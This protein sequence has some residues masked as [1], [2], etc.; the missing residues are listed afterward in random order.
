MLAAAAWCVLA[1]GILMVLAYYV[2]AAAYLDAA[3]L[4]GFNAAGH[5]E[6]IADTATVLAHLCNPLPYAIAGLMTIALA[7][8]LRGPR[9]AAA[10]TILLAG[11]NVTS[12]VLKPL[13]AY[14][15]ELYH[16]EFELYNIRDAA[17]PSGHATAAMALSLAV[18]IIVPRAYRPITA[19]LGAAF[20]IAVS[21]SV[22][23]LEWH[24]PSDV[25]GG[26]LIA[27]GYGLVTFAALLYSAERWPERGTM[28]HAAKEAIRAPSPAAIARAAL[29]AGVVGALI[30]VSKAEQIASF[31]D[32]HTAFVAVASAIAVAAAVLLAAVAAIS[33]TGSTGRHSSG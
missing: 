33:S 22:L 21:F 28:R 4:H 3:A 10:V 8:K 26:Y 23:I 32:R 5:S 29:A 19:V 1:F 17:F 25:V 7:Y 13:L 16:T 27:T 31:A 9:T 2:P 11:A 14:H 24:F 18:L 6:Q 15:R 20:T 30:A 12:Q